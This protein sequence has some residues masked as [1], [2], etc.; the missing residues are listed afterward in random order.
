METILEKGFSKADTE[1]L[2]KISSEMIVTY[3]T[4]LADKGL[5]PVTT[6]DKL[7][8]R[9]FKVDFVQVKR[10]KNLCELKGTYFNPED[11]EEKFQVFLILNENKNE[12]TS[13]KCEECNQETGPCEHAI[14]FLFWVHRRSA[15][16]EYK[17]YWSSDKDNEEVIESTDVMD[18]DQ[19]L[20]AV[21]I[22]QIFMDESI[23]ENEEI[24]DFTEEDG[25]LFLKNVLDEM[26]RI[27][28]TES[29]L[30]KHC[31]PSIDE[32]EPI[33]IHHTML[34][35]ANHYVK[36]F[37]SFVFHMESQGSEAFEKLS[38]V[39]I[40][41]Y[42]KPIWMETQYGRIRCSLMH[43]ISTRIDVSQ[44]EAIID[45]ILC[46]NR[47][48]NIEE[49]KQLKE[50]KRFILKQ[51]EKLE[52]KLYR[53]C[54]LLLSES[55]PYICASPDGVTD[56]HV[57]EIKAPKTDEEFEKYL[58]G[59][60]TIAPKYM[61]QIQIQMYLANVTK[62]LYCV[63]S[64]SFDTNGALHYVWVQADMEMVASLLSHAEDYWKDVVFPK[65]KKIYMDE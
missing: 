58:V 35:N 11:I 65:L 63:L 8:E 44:D 17:V 48:W 27:G 5:K 28:L 47:E 36:D 53:K 59:K 42:K 33:Y 31:R 13:A 43:R 40:D 19:Y 25:D 60:E 52:N 45:S 30:Y 29:A 9:K 51:T 50:H 54:G 39:S 41:N 34:D 10:T 18:D 49:K 14:S 2:P 64:P 12:V 21:Q 38:E 15:D 56:D 62:A 32:F 37:K 46:Q 4:K 57:V 6:K 3:V 23:L 20:P 61:A 7:D 26:E 16:K 22:K 1:T 55:Y 24:E